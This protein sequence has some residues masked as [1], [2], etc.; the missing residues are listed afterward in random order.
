MSDP[1][2]FATVFYLL[3][4]VDRWTSTLVANPLLASNG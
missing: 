1:T 2:I 3:P 4:V